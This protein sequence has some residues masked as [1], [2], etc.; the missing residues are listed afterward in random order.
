MDLISLIAEWA[1]KN[2]NGPMAVLL[3]VSNA[4]WIWFVLRLR[5][6]HKATNKEF[7]DALVEKEK[8][9]NDEKDARRKE[10]L[11]LQGKSYES[12]SSLVTLMDKVEAALVRVDGSMVGCMKNQR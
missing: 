3:I 5:K 1:G 4:W 7:V 8:A 11:N 12:I 9:V 10:A 2:L 6:E